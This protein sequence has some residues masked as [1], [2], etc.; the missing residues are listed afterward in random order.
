M[1]FAAEHL[2]S[3]ADC[4][5]LIGVDSI[6][7]RVPEFGRPLPDDAF[8][9]AN[10]ESIMSAVLE[11]PLE[12]RSSVRQPV[13][14]AERRARGRRGTAS[15]VRI[16]GTI[17]AV[18]AAVALV[19]SVSM[20]RDRGGAVPSVASVDPTSRDAVV[21]VDGFDVDE[22]ITSEDAWIIASYDILDVDVVAPG[23]TWEVED[24]SDEDLDALEGVF[25]AAPSLG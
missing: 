3:C 14:L 2:D 15:R 12:T 17:T 21:S 23:G 11:E 4:G 13:D 18:A 6:L 9:A 1:E 19:A 10:A 22:L 5:R 8:F 25:G 7:E 20:L 16:V 24:L